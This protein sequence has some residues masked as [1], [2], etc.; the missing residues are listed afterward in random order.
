VFNLASFG[1]PLG[2]LARRQDV[3]C[4]EGR[5]GKFAWADA[6][7]VLMQARCLCFIRRNGSMTSYETILTESIGDHLLK[8]TL[9]RPEAGNA[10]NTQM[11]LDLPGIATFVQ[12]WKAH[13]A[14]FNTDYTD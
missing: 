3:A 8:V 12:I 4:V 10:R 6:H 9:N 13:K 7:F 2:E 5:A 11:G 14:R 1:Q